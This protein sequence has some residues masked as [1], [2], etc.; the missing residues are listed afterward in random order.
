IWKKEISLGRRKPDAPAAD[1]AEPIWKKEISL[2]LRKPDAPA[3]DATEP[4]WKREIRLS[5]G[6]TPVA[7]PVENPDEW[8]PAKR[9]ELWGTRRSPEVSP[10]P[11]E[12]PVE[13]PPTEPVVEAR[14][15]AVVAV[16]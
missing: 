8:S 4:I 3:A 5:R 11:V 6:S 2:G 16:P 14:A 12:A 1:S 15:A 7:A 9:A 13:V 10:P